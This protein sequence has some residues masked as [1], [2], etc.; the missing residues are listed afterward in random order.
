MPLPTDM[1]LVYKKEKILNFIAVILLPN[2]FLFFMYNGNRKA[3]QIVFIHVL[4]LALVLAIISAIGFYLLNHLI[5]RN[6]EGSLL[7]LLLFWTLFWL[8]EA[9][10]NVIP[11]RIVG[12]RSV[13]QAAMGGIVLCFMV[14]LRFI[15]KN[16]YK[17]RIV[18]NALAAIICLLFSF[19]FFPAVLSNIR[20]VSAEESNFYIMREFNIDDTLPNPN[21]YWFHMD[22]MINFADMEFFFDDPQD[23]LRQQLVERNFIINEAA[24]FNT[25]GTAY[26][27]PALLSPTFYDSYLGNLLAAINQ[28]LRTERNVF[29]NEAFE[30][31][32]ISLS[33]DVAPYHELFNAFL[34]SGY[35]HVYIADPCASTYPPLN[36][37][38]RLNYS[39]LWDRLGDGDDM[40]DTP[41]GNISEAREEAHFLQPAYDLIELLIHTTPIPGRFGIGIRDSQL[42]WESIPEYSEEINL[43]TSSTRNLSHERQLYRRLIDSFTLEEPRLTYLTVMFAHANRWHWHYDELEGHGDHAYR[44]DLYPTAHHYAGN[45]MIN[46]IDMILEYDP[47]AVIVLQSDHGIHLQKTHNQ[48]IE[49]GFTQEEVLILFDSTISAVRIP[50]QYG[51]LDEPLD[52]RNI[53]RE[54][55]NRFVGQNYE[56]LPQ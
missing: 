49:D 20:A 8:F 55:V 56:L 6:I 15:S 39:D 36:Y 11:N 37:F 19:N 45:V 34:Q 31:D 54:L 3:S 40:D 24:R 53:T 23:E 44:F 16:F 48:L 9:I 4:I 13:L 52:P 27:V 12:S 35:S 25:E 51:G 5:V 38:Y 26:G 10:Y 2:I 30:R 46:L 50:E 17:R 7:V 18:F 21:I 1:I 47:S 22:G 14:T 28:E 41:L 43:L 42:E 33:K 32:G 29:M